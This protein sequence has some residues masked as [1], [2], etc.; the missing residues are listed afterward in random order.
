MRNEWKAITSFKNEK[1]FKDMFWETELWIVMYFLNVGG[2]DGKRSIC[3]PLVLKAEA[4]PIQ[5]V[6]LFLF[7]AFVLPTRNAPYIPKSLLKFF[8]F[9]FLLFRL[10][11]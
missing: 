6:A 4:S 5:N 9:S 1:E 7:V 8:G 2:F 3:E 10:Y 11:L